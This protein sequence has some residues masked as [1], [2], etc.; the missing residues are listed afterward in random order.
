M[1]A[2]LRASNGRRFESRC[3][4]QANAKG[5]ATA[6]PY[7]SPVSG[8]RGLNNFPRNPPTS[9]HDVV[10]LIQHSGDR[11]HIRSVVRTCFACL[12][13]VRQTSGIQTVEVFPSAPMTPPHLKNF[14]V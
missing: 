13:Q 14:P 9:V 8:Q 7:R 10:L 1:P 12:Q 5:N 3:R 2:M 11:S 6:S 4:A